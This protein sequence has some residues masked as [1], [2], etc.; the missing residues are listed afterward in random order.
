LVNEFG[1]IGID[2]DLIIEGSEDM[3]EL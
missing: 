3:I 2:N 1:E